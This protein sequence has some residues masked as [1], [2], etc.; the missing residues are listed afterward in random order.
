[1]AVSY[2]IPGN[3]YERNEAVRSYRIMDSPPE[4][5][6]DEIGEIA[7]QICDCPIATTVNNWLDCSN[8]GGG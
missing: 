1:M 4:I 2:P 3:E 6:F 8:I 7:G 5:L